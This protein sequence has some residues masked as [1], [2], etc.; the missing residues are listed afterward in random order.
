MKQ[1]LLQSLPVKE[2][3]P[4][5][6]YLQVRKLEK[7]NY[8]PM[9]RSNYQ[10][11]WI[12]SGVRSLTM[13]FHT[14]EC[15]P[16][17][18]MFMTPRMEPNLKFTCTT[19]EG[20]IIEFSPTFFRDQYLEGLNIRNIDIYYHADTF[21][22]IVLSPKIGQRINSLAEM[23]SELLQSQIPNKETAAASLL[24]TLIVYCDSNCNIRINNSSNAH[25][26]N[27]VS[28]FKHL[29]SKNLKWK[30]QVSDY[31]DM[32]NITPKYL[33]QVVKT[34]MG[35]NAKS[36]IQEQLT[37]QACRDLKFSNYS[38]KEIAINLGFQEPEH[39]TNFFRKNIG[40]S[41]QEYRHK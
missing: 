40:Y 27:I 39:F 21:P 25:Y 31:A 22:I 15:F 26:V 17:T 16:N 14:V 20:W 18:I 4:A 41:P 11:I 12:E 24:K 34:I 1:T 3:M 37:I 29:V 8:H 10:V 23:I 35:I 28:S 6:D 38:V 7:K 30:H 2:K 33:N 9:V 32:M 13:D 5:E 19:P 36:I